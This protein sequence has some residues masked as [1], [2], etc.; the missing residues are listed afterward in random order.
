V[1]K[2]VINVGRKEKMRKRKME[3]LDEGEEMMDDGG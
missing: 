3:R 2:K 1:G